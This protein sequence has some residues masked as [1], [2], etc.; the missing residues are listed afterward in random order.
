MHTAYCSPRR[1]P[2]VPSMGSMV[3]IPVEHL[4]SALN[5]IHATARTSGPPAIIVPSI[6]RVQQLRRALRLPGADPPFGL[7]AFYE[8]RDQRLVREL[9]DTVP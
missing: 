2:F 4:V 9:D 6:D 1:K 5:A 3:H 8:G 7:V